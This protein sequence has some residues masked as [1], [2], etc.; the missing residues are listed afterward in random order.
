MII[1]PLTQV[2]IYAMVLSQVLSAKLPG[3]ENKYAYA[4]YLMAGILGWTLFSEMIGKCLGLF[5]D[6]GN[7]LKK[8]AFPRISL[9]LIAAGTVLVNNVLLAAAIFCVFAVLGHAPG[10]H[11]IWLP[12]LTLLTLLLAL[13]I[14][15]ILGV[16][17]VFMRDL[18]QAV[19]VVLQLFFWLTPVVYSI[20]ALPQDLQSIFMR[21]PLYGLIASYQNVLVFDRAPDWPSLSNLSL[22]TAVLLVLAMY[23]FRRASSELVDAL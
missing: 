8:M 20:N 4:L 7:L 1:H 9:P 17:N 2:L 5:V 13:S 11:A 15:L 16:L 21:N 19:P 6:N 3:I 18:G 14:G 23:L 22:A 10:A 12:V